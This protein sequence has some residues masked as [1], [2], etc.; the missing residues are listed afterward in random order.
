MFDAYLLMPTAPSMLQARD[1]YLAADR[2][3]FGGANQAELW[4]AFA[5][6]GFGEL[7]ASSNTAA[8]TDTDPTPDFS[9]PLHK[10]ANVTFKVTGA[11]RKPIS[12]RVF[13]G[14][15]EGR[16]SPIADTD[17]ATTGVNL[18][19]K[20]SFVP[21]RYELVVRAAG[22][23]HMRVRR[24]L[25]AGSTN[26]SV[27]MQP[28]WAS[29]AQGA[30]ASGDGVRHADLIDDTEATNWERTG[31][32]PDVR[33]SQVTVDL[34]G[35][36]VHP[37]ARVQVSAMLTPGQSR[38]T[39][40]RQFEI[41]TCLAAA[42]NANCTL[43]GGWTTRLTSPA[44]A[45]PGVPPRPA[46]PDLLIRSFSL[47]A[48]VQASHVRIVV[49][50]NQCTGNPAFQ[51][52]QDADPLNGTDCRQGSPGSGTVELIGDL[53]QVLAPRDDQVQIAEL[54]VFSR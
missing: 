32:V 16:V 10:E 34:G 28:N 36:S 50:T 4:Q 31:A 33:G 20:A 8:D 12:A 39:A 47:G 35:S 14:H 51:G 54:Q 42:T 40:V 3:R 7:A 6:R 21:G 5:T 23:G 38:F 41:Q 11:D 17:P 29:A 27:E 45:F 49:L 13:V 30:T 22:Y 37:V 48:T 43:P 26:L 46:S 19:E 9:S 24:D 52:E 1:A 44:D 25:K 53:P 15:Y 18:D 2:M